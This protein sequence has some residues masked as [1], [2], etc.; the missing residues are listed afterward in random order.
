MVRPGFA[1]EDFPAMRCRF[2]ALALALAVAPTMYVYVADGTAWAVQPATL[3]QAGVDA[4]ETDGAAPAEDQREPSDEGQPATE[5]QSADLDVPL[6]QG[7]SRRVDQLDTADDNGPLA[8]HPAALAHPDHD[9][10][11]CEAGC[12]QTPGSIVYMKKRQ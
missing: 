3:A 2:C 8:P 1:E 6:R 7:D 4:S 11:V 9:V 5:D 10:I 12:D